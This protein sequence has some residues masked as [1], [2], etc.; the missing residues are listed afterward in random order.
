VISKFFEKREET[1]TVTSY[2]DIELAMLKAFGIDAEGYVSD[3]ALKEA[4]YFTCIKIMSESIAKIPCYLVLETET[5][6]LRL[7]NESLYEK[8]VLR[9]NPYMTAIDFWKAK[10]P[11]EMF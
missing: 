8:L 3:S 9:P 4:T 7:K 10:T 11:K 6:N 5:G 1:T 2:S